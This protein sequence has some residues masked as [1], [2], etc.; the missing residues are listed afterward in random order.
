MRQMLG[1]GLMRA[2]S[3]QIQTVLYGMDQAS[4]N[5]SLESIANA[6][7][8]NREGVGTVGDVTVV[9][10]DA[11]PSRTFDDGAVRDIKERFGAWFGYEYRYFNENTGTA[12]GHNRMFEGCASD[13]VVVQNPDV[14]YCPRFF[15]RMLEPFGRT[16]VQVGLVEARQAP[17]EHPKEYDPKTKVTPWSTSA[18]IMVPSAVMREVQGFD[19]ETFFLYCDDVDF[20]WRVRLTGRSLV[21][22]PLAPVYHPKYLTSHGRW[23]STDAEVYYSALA[24][25]LMLYKWSYTARC[26]KLLAEYKRGAGETEQKAAREFEQRRASGRLPLQLDPAHRVADINETGYAHLRFT[27]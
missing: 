1:R 16:D 26:E 21:Y 25:L 10:G 11:S 22:Q 27:I 24:R 23:Q 4:L 6:V 8:V 12:R 17:I 15:E 20:S 18:C 7:R 2:V 5:R 3:I 14:Q 13:Y 19:A 9:H